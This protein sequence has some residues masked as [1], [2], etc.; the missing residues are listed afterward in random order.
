MSQRFT[1][2]RHIDGQL[3]FA[4]STGITHRSHAGVAWRT[5]ANTA[6]RWD[7]ADRDWILSHWPGSMIWSE[8]WEAAA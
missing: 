5:G 7:V 3:L 1:I 2:S 8:H 6:T 4:C